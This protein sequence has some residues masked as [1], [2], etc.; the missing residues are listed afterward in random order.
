[1]NPNLPGG[2]NYRRSATLTVEPPPPPPWDLSMVDLPPWFWPLLRDLMELAERTFGP[3]SGPY[4]HD[5]VATALLRA[6]ETHPCSDLEDLG[7][8][9]VRDDLLAMFIRGV[10]ALQFPRP[11]TSTSALQMAVDRLREASGHLAEARERGFIPS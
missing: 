4:K 2:A 1:M 11:R 8:E 5:F 7:P 10:C 6:L 3:E 9:D